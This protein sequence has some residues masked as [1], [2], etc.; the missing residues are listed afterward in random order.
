MYCV[1]SGGKKKKKKRSSDKFRSQVEGRN[2]ATCHP[3]E[4]VPSRHIHSDDNWGRGPS[5]N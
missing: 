4:M 3:I 2:N 5:D 1:K